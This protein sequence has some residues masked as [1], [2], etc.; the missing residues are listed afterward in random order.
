M[1]HHFT[2]PANE[3]GMILDQHID[4]DMT[5]AMGSPF[6]VGVDTFPQRAYV[7]LVHAT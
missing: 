5:T 2:V 1:S 7:D 6:Q 3:N 4:T